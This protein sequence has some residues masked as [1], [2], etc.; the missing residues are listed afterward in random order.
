[1]QRRN[2]R[3]NINVSVAYNVTAPAGTRISIQSISGSVTDHRHQG[4]RN[5]NTISGDVRDQRRRPHRVRQDDLGHRRDRGHAG[6]TAPV[7]GSSVSGDVVLRRVTAR[8]I[9][10]GSV[11]GNIRLEDVQ[12]ERV[13]ASTTMRQRLVLAARS[14][15]TAATS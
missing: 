1:M 4:G 7:A 5:A 11:S 2:N 8:R 14:P 6:R 3:R 12:C 10:A 13:S 15:G 9:D